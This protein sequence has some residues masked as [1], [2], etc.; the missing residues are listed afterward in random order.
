[1]RSLWMLTVVAPLALLPACTIYDSDD[2][3]MTEAT[4]PTV[5]FTYR[6]DDDFDQVADRADLYC[7]EHYGN[8]A[9]LVDRDLE[10]DGYEATF[11]CE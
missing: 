1:M 3:D 6:D 4:S 11:R 10:D 5:S 9:E 7:E 8:D 2:T